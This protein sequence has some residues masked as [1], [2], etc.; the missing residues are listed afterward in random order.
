MKPYTK[1]V[2]A[3]LVFLS[4]LTSCG[5]SGSSSG[6]ESGERVVDETQIEASRAAADGS[7]IQ[8]KFIAK[9]M[10]LNPHVVGTVP[11]STQILR[12][13]DRISIFLRLFA[14]S[15]S[16]G[17]FQNVHTGTRCPVMSDDTN[18]DGYID[19]QE[20]LKVVG[21][22]LIPLDWDIGSQLSGNSIWPKAFPNGSYDYMMTTNFNR[23]WND[24]KS[25]DRNPN[26]NLAKLAPDEGLEIS[27][28]VVMV[29]GVEEIKNLPDTVSGLGRWKN[30][31]TLPITCGT[32]TPYTED[33]G[34]VYE[35]AI[36]GSVAP[37]EEGQDRPAP[38]G[39]GEDPGTGGVITGGTSNEA[40]SNDSTPGTTTGSANPT[41]STGTTSPDPRTT[42][43][44]DPRSTEPRRDD[45]DDGDDDF[46][47]CWPWER[48][49]H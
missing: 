1:N 13:E 22:V 38:E 16:I 46:D 48:D 7:N 9:F 33:P 42:P 4:L 39:S 35:D 18:G 12:E 26:D 10:T 8:G 14:G 43:N 37:V 23:F 17:H 6:N 24:L 45:G 47:I 30:F 5:R 25:E 2:T 34:V 20:A 36:P 3:S 15:P 19:I 28:K 11:G 21:P 27:G 40:G 31:Q 29:Q 49:C 41:P 44:P 32:F